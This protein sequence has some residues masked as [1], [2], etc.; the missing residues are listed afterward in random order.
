MALVPGVH[1]QLAVARKI[2]GIQRGATASEIKTAYHLK[3]K[4]THPDKG[5][6]ASAF[7]SLHNAHELLLAHASPEKPCTTIVA[8]GKGSRRTVQLIAIS[9]R[10]VTELQKRLMEMVDTQPA[11]DQQRAIDMVTEY[12]EGYFGRSASKRQ[13]GGKAVRPDAEHTAGEFGFTGA[14]GTG[15]S[16]LVGFFLLRS[17]SARVSHVPVGCVSNTQKKNMCAGWGTALKRSLAPSPE[18][19]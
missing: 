7:Q 18:G 2:L 19:R 17:D 14:A 11:A 8:A 5:G 9:H 10:A 12:G 1:A 3:A 15:K 6:S 16:K 13:R 4:L